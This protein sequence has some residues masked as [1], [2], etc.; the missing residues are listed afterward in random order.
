M[1]RWAAVG[2]QGPG[3]AGAG[4]PPGRSHAAEAAPW[5]L[6]RVRL[7]LDL[8]PGAP[9]EA[10]RR[11]LGLSGQ[12]SPGGE[13]GRGEMV[14]LWFLSSGAAR[15]VADLATEVA[16][17]LWPRDSTSRP[18]TGEALQLSMEGFSLPSDA[19]IQLLSPGDCVRVEAPGV[20]S[21]G[22]YTRG[23]DVSGK[24]PSRSAR[25]K[26]EKRK[27][28]REEKTLG[29]PSAESGGSREKHAR[30]GGAVKAPTRPR[31]RRLYS[32]ED[33]EEGDLL[34]YSVIEISPDGPRESVPR[35]GQ[36]VSVARF[37][38]EGEGVQEGPRERRRAWRQT[39]IC[40]ISTDEVAAMSQ[41]QA[42]DLTRA[43]VHGKGELVIPDLHRRSGPVAAS[44]KVPAG[45]KTEPASVRD[46]PIVPTPRS[47]R[48][49]GVGALLQGMR[50]AAMPL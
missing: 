43:L 14:K 38:D 13:E 32:L 41:F 33:L 50:E 2:S 21:Q 1:L 42:C 26:A 11:R 22:P 12:L 29:G 16:D 6:Q 35:E 27:R 40:V 8:G 34:R 36:V 25:R 15:M 4:D 5:R 7:R 47:R 19:D 44:P 10:G 3:D 46:P 28:I 37:C 17:Y 9:S 49:A 45:T 39:S 30:G 48:A 18:V 20:A 24:K 23:G 31:P